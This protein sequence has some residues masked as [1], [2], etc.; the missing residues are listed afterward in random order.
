MYFQSPPL[1]TS[2]KKKGENTDC[3]QNT[4]IHGSAYCSCSVSLPYHIVYLFTSFM[5]S[6]TGADAGGVFHSMQKKRRT[7]THTT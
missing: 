5:V 3:I 1:L 7:N 4:H 2:N 6:T